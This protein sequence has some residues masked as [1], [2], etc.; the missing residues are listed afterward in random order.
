MTNQ[1]RMSWWGEEEMYGE[2]FL[3]LSAETMDLV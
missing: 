3:P 2:K 1:R